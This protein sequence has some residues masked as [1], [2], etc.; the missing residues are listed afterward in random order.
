MELPMAISAK[1][2]KVITPKTVA[3]YIASKGGDSN[4]KTG[5]NTTV[6]TDAQVN[7]SSTHIRKKGVSTSIAATKSEKVR[8]A[9]T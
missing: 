5:H 3:T 4:N 6:V 2:I 9:P 1:K 7:T 8:H